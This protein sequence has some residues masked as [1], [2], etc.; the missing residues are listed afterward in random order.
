MNN[1]EIVDS[2]RSLYP[3]Q[4]FEETAVMEVVAEFK[5]LK[6]KAE[7]K[8]PNYIYSD[9]PL[10]PYC[11]MILDDGDEYCEC[12]QRLDFGKEQRCTEK[13]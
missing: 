5:A 13:C 6:E 4:D 11:Q 8:K 2:L 3:L 12:G 1:I 10:C 9:E 7:P